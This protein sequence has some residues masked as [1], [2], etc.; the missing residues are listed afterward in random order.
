MKPGA[1]ASR[2][3]PRAL[4]AEEFEPL[5][6]DGGVG[7][8]RRQIQSI[9][10]AASVLRL[11]TRDS[12]PLAL[13]DVARELGLAKGTAHGILRT[14]RLHGFVDQDADSGRY[15]L[16]PA[17]LPMGR[18]YLESHPVRTAA[19]GPAQWL[20]TATGH[21]ISV[22]IVYEGQVLVIH[23]VS[24]PRSAL[25]ELKTGQVLP[26]HATALGKAILSEDGELQRRLVTDGLR[27][28]STT[29]VT[30]PGAVRRQLRRAAARGWAEE[31]GELLPGRASI[32]AA[33][34]G[35]TPPTIGAIGV[36][37]SAQQLYD[38]DRARAELVAAVADSARMISARLGA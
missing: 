17:T 33:F 12:C 14:L 37:G 11:L 7:S 9:S 15:K 18:S 31:I 30:H 20:A 2:A 22:G 10:R 24:T 4:T 25:H 8:D 6:E 34:R 35:T 32:A 27:S 38:G 23:H 16:G 1:A 28:Y 3:A 26:A 19:L 29:T 36:E 21:S 5:I 13:A